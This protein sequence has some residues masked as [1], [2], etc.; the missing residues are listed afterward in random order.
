MATT[1]VARP[2][3]SLLA[4]VSSDSATMER[5]AEHRRILV[6][7]G[8]RVIVMAAVPVIDDESI[9]LTRSG[10]P[11]DVM[12]GS[13]HTP[14]GLRAAAGRTG[15]HLI[16]APDGNRVARKLALSGST[17][18]RGPGHLVLIVDRVHVASRLRVVRFMRT[19][20]LW[21]RL[22]L[23]SRHTSIDIVVR[24]PALT[25][26]LAVP[27]APPSHPMVRRLAP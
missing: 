5:A 12:L 17:G 8:Y 6:E 1:R 7:A 13:P 22:A 25:S 16:V 9:V 14:N 3:V 27:M 24:E 2:D 11:G 21:R 4:I 15:A 18:W 20:R 19:R 26:R 23:L 10:D